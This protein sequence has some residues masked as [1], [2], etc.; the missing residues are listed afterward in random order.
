[1]PYAHLFS[2]GEPLGLPEF[3]EVSLPACHGLRT[4]A[5]LHALAKSGASVLPSVYVKTLVVRNNRYFEAVPAL[6]GARPPLQPAGFSV[7]A[8]PSCSPF[9][10]PP[11]AQ[12]SIRVGG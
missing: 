10:A 11:R 2:R 4:P 1:M 9:P 6:Q 5:N 7:Y 3:S 8:R 12:D